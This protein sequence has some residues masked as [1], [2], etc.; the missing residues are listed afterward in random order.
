MNKRA[1]H[2]LVMAG[3]TGGHVFPGLAVARLMRSQGWQV[4]WLGTATRMEADLV[5]KY[6]FDIEF[7]D[8]KG[9]RGNGLCRKL[10]APWKIAKAVYQARR[11]MQKM[12]PTVALGMGGFAS[13]PGGLAAKLL[14]VPLVIHEQN[15][16]AG[17]T[18][19]WL[20]RFANS[21]LSAFPNVLPRGQTVG[22]P[23]RQE[24][25]SVGQSARIF[26]Q[27][28]NVLVIGGSL[29]AQV[30]NES[31]PQTIQ[32]CGNLAL[33]V[34]HQV[35]RGNL[36][37]TLQRYR[38][39]G[40]NQVQVDEFIDDMAQAYRWADVVICRAGAL[41]VSELAAAGLPAIFIPLPH[42][43]DDH[44]TRNANYLVEAGAA[45]I[46]PQSQL[47]ALT[48][49]EQLQELV[50]PTLREHMSKQAL[51][52]AITD[53]TQQVAGICQQWLKKE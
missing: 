40:I 52:V 4:T 46:L 31:L 6:G 26:S 12:K 27:R 10:A 13:G 24:V 29:G 53:S 35:G 47:S 51:K 28:M 3:G 32:S 25:L 22:N 39:L 19:R 1:P 33:Q 18:N 21:V 37:L 34:R 11:M 7:L 43:V 50:S 17:M 2:L 36:D 41:T 44:Q 30:L 20:S 38:A 15:A 23:V 5:P 45:R 8:I 48:L 49:S 9:V 42:A 14:G 16:V